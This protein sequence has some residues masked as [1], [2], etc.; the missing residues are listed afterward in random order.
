MKIWDITVPIHND[1]TKW[2]SHPPIE[3]KKYRDLCCGDST[4]SSTLAMSVHTGTHIDAPTHFLKDGAGV[5]GIPLDR[6]VGPCWVMQSDSSDEITAADLETAQ[7]PRGTRRLLIR[8]PN[9]RFWQT[10]NEPFHPEFVALSRDAALWIVEQG[11]QLIGIDY[12]AIQKYKD[13][14]SQVHEILFQ[15]QVV[16]VEGLKLG[17][18]SAGAYDLA[19]LP[20]LIQGCDGSPARV[21]LT[22]NEA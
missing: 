4:N 14:A 9:S 10:P 6:L 12:L 20:L 22:R 2:P 11:I 3:V 16:I 19:C 21:I 1:M 8:T 5:D 7:I 13:S 15:A 17:E 18:V